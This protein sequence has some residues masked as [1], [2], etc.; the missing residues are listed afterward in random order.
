[1]AV[2]RVKVFGVH[3]SSLPLIDKRLGEVKIDRVVTSTLGGPTGVQTRID[4]KDYDTGKPV[5]I[6]PGAFPV[7]ITEE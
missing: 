1:M 6:L 5:I 7:L 2:R 3:G 4:G